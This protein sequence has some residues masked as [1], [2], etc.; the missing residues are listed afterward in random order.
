MYGDALKAHLDERMRVFRA[1]ADLLWDEGLEPVLPT[2]VAGYPYNDDHT[3]E[4]YLA[5]DLKLV[6]DVDAIAMLPG[7]EES[8]GAQLE[9]YVAKA[10]GK[11]VRYLDLDQEFLQTVE[12]SVAKLRPVLDALAAS[13]K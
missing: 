6:V 10:L 2:G 3:W 9:L 5:G 8:K 7:W 1:A 11:K 12:A 13:D 4:Y